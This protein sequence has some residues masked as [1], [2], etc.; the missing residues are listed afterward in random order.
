[1]YPKLQIISTLMAQLIKLICK[2]IV[3]HPCI[4]FFVLFVPEVML[5]LD[6][7]NFREYF[8]TVIIF[9]K[10]MNVFDRPWHGLA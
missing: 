3:S 7:K 10:H 4:T 9:W 5:I 1:M 2:V 6:F 8:F